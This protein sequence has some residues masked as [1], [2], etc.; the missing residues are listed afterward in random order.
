MWDECLQWS[1]GPDP[2]GGWWRM[3]RMRLYSLVTG[4][5]LR[6][7]GDA[8]YERYLEKTPFRRCGSDG[9][10]LSAA[11]QQLEFAVPVG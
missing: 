5:Y 3:R 7:E 2:T 4:Y 11:F 10:L 1:F 9:A 8:E 6:F